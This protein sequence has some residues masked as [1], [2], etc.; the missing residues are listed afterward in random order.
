MAVL[1]T[2]FDLFIVFA[3]CLGAGFFIANI[4]SRFI[5]NLPDS[6]PK[7]VVELGLHGLSGVLCVII[8][9]RAIFNEGQT[10]V[11]FEG[12]PKLSYLWFL[13]L[14]F[15]LA[16]FMVFTVMGLVRIVRGP[17]LD[18]HTKSMVHPISFKPM[19]QPPLPRV[20]QLFD[21]ELVEIEIAIPN[22]DPGLTGLTV[23]NLTDFH[24][25]KVCTQDYVRHAIDRLME[26]QPELLAITGDFVNYPR[27]LDSCFDLLKGI[28]APL[29]VY[30]VRGNHDFWVGAED[31]DRRIRQLG[32]TLLHDRAVE[33]ERNGAPT[34][35]AGI[36]SP[37]NMAGVPLDFIPPDADKLKIVLSHT[38]DE[39]PR[40]ARQNPHLVLSGHTHGG[41]ICIPFFGSVVVPS[42]Y[43]RK[44]ER[45]F[46]REGESLLYVSRGIGCHP[47]IRTLCKPEV[48]LFRFVPGDP[49]TPHENPQKIL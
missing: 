37:W 40:L 32:M 35:V 38:P 12:W 30:V 17:F 14:G 19:T 23:G 28:S 34:L 6:R 20:N 42:N 43:G 10:F 26:R 2:V 13:F 29:G 36:E 9:L 41:Q 8:L 31:I 3:A 18:P 24:L 11:Q 1:A 7:V 4:M 16:T 25:G 47:P 33:V 15:A 27:H 46:F 22:L 48:T 45:G 39:F 49:I 5:C 21:L 44:Y